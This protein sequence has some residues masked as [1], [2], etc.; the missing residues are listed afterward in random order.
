M[1][2]ELTEQIR[3]HKFITEDKTAVFK[4]ESDKY[5]VVCSVSDS[6][7]VSSTTDI[8]SRDYHNAVVAEYNS[9]LKLM[10]AS[11]EVMSSKLGMLSSDLHDIEKELAEET[12][13]IK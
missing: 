5:N 13:R 2:D 1:S 10:V 6:G 4:T 3:L 8:V 12:K 7:I 11:L 9:K